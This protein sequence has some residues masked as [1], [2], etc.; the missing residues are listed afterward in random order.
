MRIVIAND[1]AAVELKRAVV[2]H[3]VELG[4]EV[5]NLGADTEASTD[6]PLWGAAAAKLVV[7]GTADLGIVICG[8][9]QGIGIAANK[10]RGIRCVICADEYSARMGRAHNNANMLAFGARVVG[11]GLALEIVD[12]FLTTQFEGVRH[13]R[14]VG[15]LAALDAGEDVPS[16][17]GS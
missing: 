15:Q 5:E 7:A 12:A 16:P 2:E 6:Y 17:V 10:V 8:T 1:H 13:A 4:Y 3:L 11:P 9:G 14:R